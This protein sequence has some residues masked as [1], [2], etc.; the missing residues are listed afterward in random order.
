[1]N[2]TR[3]DAALRAVYETP[4]EP[5]TLDSKVQNALNH[6]ARVRIVRRRVF[7]SVAATGAAGFALIAFPAVQA[8]ASIAGIT[9]ALDS[10]DKVLMTT[11]TVDE[12]GA[13]S[14]SGTSVIV[15]GDW[16]VRDALGRRE[17]ITK[18]N[19]QYVFDPTIKAYIV[20]ENPRQ[21]HVKLSEMLGPTGEF[22]LG[23]RA[24]I[25]HTE[26]G[27]K[28]MIRAVITNTGLPERY[29]ID[30]DEKTDLPV[31]AQVESLE[32]GH[33]RVRQVMSFEYKSNL[34]IP[35]PDLAKFKVTTPEAADAEFTKS[36]EANALGSVK[37]VKGRLV[38]RSI[39]VSQE[40]TVFVAYQSGNHTP[41]SFNGYALN[42][43]DNLNTRYLR[44]GQF[45]SMM[46]GPFNTPDGKIEME[47]FCPLNPI[48][49]NLARKLTLTTQMEASGKLIRSIQFGV[50]DASGHTV[51]HWQLNHMGSVRGKDVTLP[52]LSKEIS[53]ATCTTHPS[54]AEPLDY[55]RF[56]NDIS[57]ELHMAEA[58]GKA[59]MEDSRWEDAKTL[60]NEELRL[61]REHERK[62]YGPW[63]LNQALEYL[64]QAKA[65]VYN[66]R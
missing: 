21:A 8:Q 20:R 14:L 52:V 31:D 27:G 45:G 4:K 40:G 19:K 13:K 2:E 32:R 33:W 62:G 66:P 50:T 29:V 37:F 26:I 48:P 15:G 63:D 36:M 65:H 64:D 17:S 47:I 61:M 58:R 43:T 39:D 24:E 10:A 22:S 30:A 12:T 23:K 28:P 3:F 6:Q 38:V 18:G 60:F 1:M 57:T 55:T 42:L 54:W 34:T 49:S 51:L 11:Y 9:K 44:V 56:S 59:A 53:G 5:V 41:R 7:F 25:E 16:W 46:E 35:G